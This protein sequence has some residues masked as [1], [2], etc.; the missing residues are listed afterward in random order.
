MKKRSKMP[1]KKSKKLF[2]KTAKKTH[3]K[4][5]NNMPM[6]GGIRM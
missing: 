4:N 3:K 1:M 2:S 5:L 6:R